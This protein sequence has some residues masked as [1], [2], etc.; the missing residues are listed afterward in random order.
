MSLIRLIAILVATLFVTA[1]AIAGDWVVT[2][3]RGTVEQRVDEAWVPLKRGDSIEYDR[4]VRTLADGHAELQRNL[5]VLTLDVNTTIRI[6][7]DTET[8]F[9]TVLQEFGRLEVDAEVKNVKHFAVQTAYLAAVVKGTRFIVTTD[10]DGTTVA[11]DRGAVGVT[12]AASERST[13]ITVGQTATVEKKKDLTVGGLG[14]WPP[15]LEKDAASAP[16][17]SAAL[18]GSASVGNV[19]APLPDPEAAGEPS[20]TQ[21]AA[22]PVTQIGGGAVGDVLGGDSQVVATQAEPASPVSPTVVMIG[23]LIGAAL[24]ALALFFRRIVH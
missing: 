12:S 22:G 5:E 20:P 1:P 21:I 19:A 18:T 17:Q 23:V 4:D 8:G 14:P 2:R 10:L 13:T 3:L 7:Q 15:I 9:T 6:Q 24:G 11:V 16:V